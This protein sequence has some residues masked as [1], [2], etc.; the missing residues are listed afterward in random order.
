VSLNGKIALFYVLYLIPIVVIGLLVGWTDSVYYILIAAVVIPVCAVLIF[1]YPYSGF[2]IYMFVYYVR[3]GERFPALE[4]LRIEL[5]F[6]VFLLVVMAIS[7]ALH[8]RGG[9]TF[10]KDKITIAL[11]AFIVVL[12]VSTVFS[13]WV[14]ASYDL[15]VDFIK[16]FI[17]YLFIVIMSDTEKRF[18]LT[19]WLV[20]LFTAWI[21]IE[22]LYDYHTGGY[23][24]SMGIMRAGGATSLGEH[25]NSLAL[26]MASVIPML[27]YLF[28]RYR[29]QIV[30]LCILILIGLCLDSLL[31]TGSR[32]GVLAIIGTALT[33]AW[34]SRRRWAYLGGIIILAVVIWAVL[35]QQYRVR[36]SSMTNEEV[37]ASSQGR[38]NAWKAGIEMFIEKPIWGVGPEVF[39]AAY[40][41]RQGVWLQSHSLYVE[42]LAT[43]GLLGTAAWVF[44]I[45]QFFYMLKYLKHAGGQSPGE[46]QDINVFVRANYAIL[47]GLFVAGIFGH[48]LFRDTWYILAALVVARYNITTQAAE[49]A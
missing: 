2:F 21:G 11:L 37:D 41:N 13:E 27:I 15:V 36:Y 44:F 16:T 25:P 8:R 32:S 47:V 48:I 40:F 30:R 45:I 33:Y 7:D 12:A 23:R 46:E 19:F 9:I 35:P 20:V 5:T 34:F 29:N 1:R 18:R 4:P 43:V 38:L 3:P 26:Y 14:T 28:T 10:P 6:G 42:M 24:I 39:A 31:V 49:T 17:L 22:A